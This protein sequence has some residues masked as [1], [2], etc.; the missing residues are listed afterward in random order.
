MVNN[1]PKHQGAAAP[2][3]PGFW[4]L[5]RMAKGREGKVLVCNRTEKAAEAAAQ[6]EG[7][8]APKEV[9]GE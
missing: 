6:V 1:R 8:A 5:L 2:W 4:T 3:C 7:A 9:Q